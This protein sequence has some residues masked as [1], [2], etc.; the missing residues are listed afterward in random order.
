MG[1]IEDKKPDEVD[2]EA[3]VKLVKDCRK[4]ATSSQ[5]EWRDEARESYDMVA[6]KQ[7]AEEDAQKLTS[8]GRVAA[9]F[10]RLRTIND[11]VSGSEVNNRQEVRYIPRE[12]GDVAVNEVLTSAAQ[13]VRDNCDAEDEESD[14]FV[15]V[16]V[17]GMGWTETRMDYEQDEEGKCVISRVDPLEMRWDPAARKRN[18]ADARWVQRERG[19]TREEIE[20]RWPDAEL[21]DK[22][23]L[24]EEEDEALQIDHK[25]DG[26]VGAEENKATK[27]KLYS[28]IHHQWYD[29]VP[30]YKVLSPDTG[31]IIEVPEDRYPAIEQI[32]LSQGIPLKS[33]KI[34]RRA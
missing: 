16:L 11:A 26:Y 3:I 8:E 7:W 4:D 9:V 17:S 15:D 28:V 31:Q 13:W 20:A 33:A 6:G 18:L 29:I 22:A 23:E 27:R 5:A 32:A 24:D 34:S 1:G 12:I 2:E 30:V 21:P 19:F 14:A 10:N 25:P